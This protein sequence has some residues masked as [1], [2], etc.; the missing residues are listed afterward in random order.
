MRELNRNKQTLWYANPTG[1]TAVTDENGLKTGEKEI[2]YGS[3]VAVRMSVAVSSGA[4]NLGSQGI[5]EL[6]PYGITTGY[7]HRA[8]TEDLSCDMNEESIVWYR[9]EPTHEEQRQTT[10]NGETVTVAEEVPNP[11]NFVVVRKS[12]SLTHVTYYLKEVD[13]G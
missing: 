10:V 9:I 11:H 3:P 5:A 6:E 13:V 8:V 4:N 12:L 7:T 1:E 2:T